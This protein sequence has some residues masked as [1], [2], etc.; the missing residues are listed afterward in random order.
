[1][2]EAIRVYSSVDVILIDDIELYLHIETQ[3]D[4]LHLIQLETQAQ[5]ICT[6]NAP[7]IIMK[8]WI[9]RVISLDK[10]KNRLKEVYIVHIILFHLNYILC[11]W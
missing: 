8:G 1:M 7:G 6:T 3:F 11:V 5:I 2:M 4:L 9:D 10:E